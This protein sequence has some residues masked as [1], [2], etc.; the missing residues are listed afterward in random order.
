MPILKTG[1]WEYS[2]FVFDWLPDPENGKFGRFGRPAE[3]SAPAGFSVQ[4]VEKWE[5]WIY[6]S[7]TEAFQTAY[8]F[9]GDQVNVGKLVWLSNTE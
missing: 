9:L 3:P 4:K 7:S 1:D 2:E 8:M 5:N 6:G